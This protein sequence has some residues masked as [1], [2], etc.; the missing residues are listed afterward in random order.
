MG[1]SN[2]DGRCCMFHARNEVD[3]DS[4]HPHQPLIIHE[5]QFD[6]QVCYW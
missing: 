6:G 2:G 5:M 4:V 1:S 3:G